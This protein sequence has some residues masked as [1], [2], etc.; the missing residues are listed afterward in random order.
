[1]TVIVVSTGVGGAGTSFIAWWLAQYIRFSRDN[2]YSADISLCPTSAQY[3][4]LEVAYIKIYN[5][6]EPSS[7]FNLRNLDIWLDR[8]LAQGRPSVL[9]VSA[10]SFLPFFSYAQEVMFLFC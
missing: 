2:P 10:S 4:G 3:S 5:S 9:D 7:Q 8:V 6:D 1:M